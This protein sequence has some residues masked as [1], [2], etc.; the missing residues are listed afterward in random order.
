MILL[1]TTVD[2]LTATASVGYTLWRGLYERVSSLTIALTPYS[3]GT[4]GH[5][6]LFKLYTIG[7]RI[8]VLQKCVGLL[9]ELDA[10]IQH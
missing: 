6:E 9:E 8:Q 4:Y 2:A 1:K 5:H 10:P 3:V 7:T